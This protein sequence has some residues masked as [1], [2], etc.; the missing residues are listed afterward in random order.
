[1]EWLPYFFQR[2]EIGAIQRSNEVAQKLHAK[3]ESLHQA[4]AEVEMLRKEIAL[5]ADAFQS[6]LAEVETLRKEN[7]V[8]TWNAHV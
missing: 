5:N 3:T 8:S 7:A 2:Q 6:A 1:M 4:M